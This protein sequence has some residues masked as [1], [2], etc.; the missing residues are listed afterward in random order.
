MNE[1]PGIRLNKQKSTL[2]DPD[3]FEVHRDVPKHP[4]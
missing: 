3:E 4:N 2:E 1:V